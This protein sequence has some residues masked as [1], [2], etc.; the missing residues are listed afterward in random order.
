MNAASDGASHG[1][2][3][4]RLRRALAVTAVLV[5][6]WLFVYWIE[7]LALFSLLERLTPT[8]V[9]RV[10]TERPLV[11]LSFD[12]GPDPIYTPQVLDVLE[13]ND[14]HATFFLIGERALRH[15]ELRAR[16]KGAG[17]EVGNHYFMNGSTLGHS[18]AD[19]I[20]YLERTEKAAGVTG[21]LKL[22]RPPG[23]VAWPRQ[24]R[25]ARERGYTCVLG[26]AYPHDPVHPPVW[27]IRWLT[28][29]NLT[30]GAIVVLHDGI[31]D[32]TRSI[33]ALPHI[34]AAGRRR[35]LRFVSVGTLMSAADERRGRP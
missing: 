32:P 19:F 28:E 8:V 24:L 18:D 2:S 14:A 29:K 12:D 17:H 34:L 1:T 4:T 35:G 13:R 10:K 22:F 21:P 23:G 30:P 6:A 33:E 20:A 7:P 16:I 27:Y 3:S 25:L 11:A 15:P 9:Y 26:S 5:V 31:S